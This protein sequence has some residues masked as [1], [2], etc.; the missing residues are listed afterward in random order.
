MLYTSVLSLHGNG[1]IQLLKETARDI[2]IRNFSICVYNSTNEQT[3]SI[4]SVKICNSLDNRCGYI[5]KNIEVDN[6]GFFIGKIFLSR[7]SYIEVEIEGDKN[8]TVDVII[9]YTEL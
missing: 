8:N 3:Y 2:Y 1:E 6:K 9:S 4:I 5:V 7:N